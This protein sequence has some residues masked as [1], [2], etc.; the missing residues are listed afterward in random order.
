[1]IVTGDGDAGS[2]RFASSEV[3]RLKSPVARFK[4]SNGD[5]ASADRALWHRQYTDGERGTLIRID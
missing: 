4:R 1:M 2:H 5:L 3:P